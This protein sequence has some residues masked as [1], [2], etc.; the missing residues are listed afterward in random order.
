MD[1]CGGVGYV[2]S[3]M[4][5]ASI[6]FIYGGSFKISLCGFPTYGAYLKAGQFKN[7]AL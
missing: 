3:K 5:Y 7:E 1:L 6:S 2:L 4:V